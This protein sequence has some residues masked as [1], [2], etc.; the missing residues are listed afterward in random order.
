MAI[1]NTKSKKN[2]GFAIVLVLS[3]IATILTIVG[4]VVYQTQLVAKNTLETQNQIQARATALTGVSIAK[5][6]IKFHTMLSA[7]N[8]SALPLNLPKNM[9]ASLNNVKI[10]S[11][12]LAKNKAFVDVI[13]DEVL[14][15]LQQ[16]PGYFMINVSI[17]N[18]KFNLNLLRPG[19]SAYAD[20][21]LLN[22]FSTPDARDV[23]M[24]YHIDPNILVQ[25]L[26]EYVNTIKRPLLSVQD[27]RQ[28]DGFQ[29]DDIYNM[30]APYFTV[31]PSSAEDL[32][33]TPP[34]NINCAPIELLAGLFRPNPNDEINPVVW[35]SFASVRGDDD[36]KFKSFPDLSEWTKQNAIWF[37]TGKLKEMMERMVG[38]QNT[39]Y[40]IESKGVINQTEQNITVIMHVDGNGK[41]I[42]D[43][44]QWSS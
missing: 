24:I 10:G 37:N 16:I 12:T 32:T 29:Y 38:F 27:I 39:V 30:Y 25:N 36:A 6:L 20:S 35:Q 18:C 1:M 19:F 42:V 7:K 31:W 4:D 33:K 26:K 40:R 2:S 44:N 5:T 3:F 8:I 23:F 9:Y 21:A 34:L 11:A 14:Q 28:V 43:Y 22:L 15:T 41:G 17:E 13:P